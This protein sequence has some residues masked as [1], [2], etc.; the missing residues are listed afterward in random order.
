LCLIDMLPLWMAKNSQL[1]SD[2]KDSLS[3][4]LL[5]VSWIF[6]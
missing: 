5:T 2:L 4:L 6:F 3:A 1:L